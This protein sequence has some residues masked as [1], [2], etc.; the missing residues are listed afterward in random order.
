MAPGIEFVT[1]NSIRKYQVC[2][3]VTPQKTSAE[4]IPLRFFRYCSPTISLK[5]STILSEM[6]VSPYACV[7][8]ARWARMV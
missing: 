1:E 5:R 6:S 4:A 3:P 7:R 2:K 8:S